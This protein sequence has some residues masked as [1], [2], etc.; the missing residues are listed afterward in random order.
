MNIQESE[1]DEWSLKSDPGKDRW[2]ARWEVEPAGYEW[3]RQGKV[4]Y[5]YRLYFSPELKGISG[6]PTRLNP[7]PVDDDGPWLAPLGWDGHESRPPR[8]V[9]NPLNYAT[10]E[11]PESKRSRSR[12]HRRFS[13][14]PLDPVAI[15]QFAKRFGLL[16]ERGVFLEGKASYTY[17][18]SFSVWCQE[19]LLVQRLCLWW[20]LV[21]KRKPESAE[22]LLQYFD[23]KALQGEW[24]RVDALGLELP[25]QEG[26]PG[27]VIHVPHDTLLQPQVKL[28]VQE[29]VLDSTRQRY[30]EMGWYCPDF[31]TLTDPNPDIFAVAGFAVNELV[32]QKLAETTRVAVQFDRRAKPDQAYY[33]VVES[34]LGAIYKSFISE[35]LGV[36]L[37]ERTCPWC[38]KP[39][40][41]RRPNQEFCTKRHQLNFAQKRSR[42]ATKARAGL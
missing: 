42:A 15:Q 32:N 29:P 26:L 19:I 2:N 35:M 21:R 5:G 3:S 34:L 13:R 12:L 11:E 33:F 4:C 39:F 40:E 23:P 18:E 30:E 36:F 24:L 37:P 28:T 20:D 6:R 1:R 31:W 8:Q 14:L 9:Y 17:A 7:P 10:L 22:E 25:S 38:Q 41:P 16:G 27:R